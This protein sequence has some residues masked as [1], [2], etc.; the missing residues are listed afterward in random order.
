LTQMALWS[1]R[2]ALSQFKLPSKLFFE[3]MR[4]NWKVSSSNFMFTVVFSF[5]NDM[6]LKPS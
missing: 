3:H 2:S 6:D 1:L 4:M 5:I